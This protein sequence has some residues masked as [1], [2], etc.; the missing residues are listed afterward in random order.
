MSKISKL[1][2]EHLAKLARLQL[3]EKEKTKFS[4]ELS[5]VLGYVEKLN[6]V[7]TPNPTDTYEVAELVNVYRED[8]VS[9]I[10][11][12]DKNPQKNTEKLLANAP[13]KKDRYW[14]VKQ[15]LE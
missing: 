7:K 9:D 1:E 14:K 4:R 13:E 11:K 2:I 6:K 3:S 10:W 8:K 5:E 15:V 12:T